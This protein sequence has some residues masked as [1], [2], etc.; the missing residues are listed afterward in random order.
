VLFIVNSSHQILRCTC[1]HEAAAD[2]LGS[3]AYCIIILAEMD[4]DPCDGKDHQQ[5][6]ITVIFF[7]LEGIIDERQLHHS[8]DYL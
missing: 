6:R 2:E 5:Q 4:S 1:F 8:R 3:A 7:L